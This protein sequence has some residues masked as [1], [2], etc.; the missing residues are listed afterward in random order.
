MKK[1]RIF[2][3]ML[4]MAIAPAMV[5]TAGASPAKCGEHGTKDTMLVSTAWL[6]EHL[7]DANVV[8]LAVGQKSDYD[9]G[10][11]PGSI[12]ADY[13]ETHL[14]NSPAGLT[15]EL[16]PP[17]Q[18]V[19]VFTSLG[20]TNDS[21]I[22]L[23]QAKDWFSPTARVFMTLDAMG[24]GSRTSV[25]DGGFLLWSKEG[26][27]VSKEETK[28]TKTG[29]VTPC[30]TGDVIADIAYVSANM[31][32]AG[33]A[34]VD[35]RNEEFYTGKTQPNEQRR[36]HI[37]G[38][39]SLPFTALADENGKLKSTEVL[40][41]LFR[42]AGVKRGDRVVAYCHI[43]QQASALYFVARYLGYDARLFDGSWEQ[44]SGRKDLPAETSPGGAP[45]KQ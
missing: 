5:A 28:A 6:A 24:F 2:A 32:K 44:W 8:V 20:V 4:V 13:H 18:F 39:G 35:A 14:M 3:G 36:G 41:G 40:E 34:I 27:P 25:L 1:I 12:F 30:P 9:A 42:G 29:T 17:D 38:A 16:L 22:I 37:P 19:K 45:V 23:Y 26:R 10:H 15:I 31:R 21:H 11:I 33:V 7:H 43:G